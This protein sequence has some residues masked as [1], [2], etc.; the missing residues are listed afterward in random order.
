MAELWSK[1]MSDDLAPLTC[2]LEQQLASLQRELGKLE[3]QLLEVNVRLQKVEF[4][5]NL[6]KMEG[7]KDYD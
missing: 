6:K 1:R 4:E 7:K 3:K 2:I 5:L